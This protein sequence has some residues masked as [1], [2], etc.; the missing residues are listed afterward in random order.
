[1]NFL[2]LLKAG[3]D[4]VPGIDVLFHT[5][6]TSLDISDSQHNSNVIKVQYYVMNIIMEQKNPMYHKDYIII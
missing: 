1:M 6:T 2:S 3:N 5:I 4:I